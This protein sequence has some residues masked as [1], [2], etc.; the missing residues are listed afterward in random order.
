MIYREFDMESVLKAY[1]RPSFHEAMIGFLREHHE[2]LKLENAC[3]GGWPL[4]V[5]SF[6]VAGDDSDREEIRLKLTVSFQ[7]SMPGGCK[8]YND[9]RS[10][11]GHLEVVIERKAGRGSVDVEEREREPEF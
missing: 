11:T 6:D 8:D 4:P 9:V 5:D 7:E 2:E 10:R 3:D 1:G